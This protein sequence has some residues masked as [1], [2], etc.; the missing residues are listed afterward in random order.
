MS[1]NSSMVETCAKNG[2][3]LALTTTN[4]SS[5]HG[6][7]IQQTNG[8]KIKGTST[9]FQ[10]EL[11]WLNI[12][13]F[14]ILHIVAV[15]GFATFPYFQKKRTFFFSYIVSHMVG[16]GI[17]AGAHRLW[18]HRAYKAKLPLKIF[19][20]YCYYTSGQFSLY[21]WV[22]D[23]RVHHKYS[24]TEADPHNSKRGFF[25]S[26]IGWL[27]MKKRPEVI[28]RGCEIDMRDI[29]KDPIIV[30]AEKYHIILNILCCFVIPI[31]IPVYFW[32][33]GWYYSIMATN[34]RFIQ[35]LNYTWSVNSFAHMWG[36]KPYDKTI[37]PVENK[38]VAY[39]TLGE[40]FHNYHHMFPYDYKCAELGIYNLNWT[41]C[42][43]DM[44]AKIGW[45]YD[46]KQPS[47]ELIKAVMNKKGNGSKFC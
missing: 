12:I 2:N 34:A 44:F 45:A 15:Y 8:F 6:E 27:L 41:T 43:I 25:F 4:I 10:T 32:H 39:A 20:L 28:K 37:A 7:K 42:L 3:I 24:E 21:N 40:G 18:T 31:I 23:H 36:S 16:F 22:R 14:L 46:L 5:K 26:H 11:K 33:E 35:T 29:L 13:I 1:L 19:L 17:T 38:L 30:F 47:K 9:Y